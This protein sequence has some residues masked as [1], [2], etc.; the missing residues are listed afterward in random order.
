MTEQNQ[1]RCLYCMNYKYN[2]MYFY[3]NNLIEKLFLSFSVELFADSNLTLRNSDQQQIPP[4]PPHLCC[5][6]N[7]AC[8][9]TLC[10]V[11][12]LFASER[13]NNLTVR[14]KYNFGKGFSGKNYDVSLANTIPDFCTRHQTRTLFRSFVDQ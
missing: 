6:R 14:V 3:V 12:I 2:V 5:T 11:Y 13:F 4:P 1:F 8:S 10:H 9:I 7:N